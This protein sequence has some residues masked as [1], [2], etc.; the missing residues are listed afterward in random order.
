LG[1]TGVTEDNLASVNDA[2]ND[3]DVTGEQANTAAK[4]QAIVDGFNAILAN[5]DGT[6]N[7]AINPTQ[8]NYTAIGVSGVDTAP[9]VSLLGDV[10]DG[11]NRTNV[12]T[13]SQVQTLANAVQ[14]VMNGNPTE[15]QLAAL[16]ITGVTSANLGTVQAALATPVDATQLNTLAGVQSVVN[17]AIYATGAIQDAAQNNTATATTPSVAQYLAAGVTGVDANNLA[18]I[19]DALN[20]PDVTGAQADTTAKVQAIVDG[21]NAILNNA[22][23]AATPN[24]TLSNYAAIGVNGVDSAVKVNLL[25]DVIDTL[26]PA[27]V[28]QVAQVQAL[29]DAVSAV[30]TAAA[31]STGGTS[32]LSKAQLEALGI[33]GVT[34]D[35]LSAVRAAIVATAD[36]GN[37]VD[38]LSELQSLVSIAATNAANALTALGTFAQANT[39]GLATPTG[40]VPAVSLYAQAGVTGVSDSNLHA[41]NDA[42]ASLAVDSTAVSTTAQVQAIVDAYNAILGEANDSTNTPGDTTPDATPTADPT[43]ANYA[44]IG[45]NIGAAATDTENLNLLNDIIGGLQTTDVDSIAKI[46]TLA[47]IANAIQTVAANGS[48]TLTEADFAQVGLTGVTPDNLPAVLAVIA[49]TANDGS[50]TDSL[51]ELQTLITSAASA[52]SL[53]LS[54]ISAYAELNN[55]GLATASGTAPVL[56]DFTAAGVFGV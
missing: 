9:E 26:A 14:A 40:A 27:D 50:Q 52:A 47:N 35:N 53:A 13:V 56:A 21:F 15:A 43:A 45:A 38:S 42:L 44:A 4:V 30:M 23:I 48:A 17:N 24:P 31:V 11:K 54:T 39:Q 28:S 32:T 7:N 10:I 16:G 46:N 20:D 25:G 12:D 3:A 2:L 29:A 49:A 22:T 6:A 37:A 34:D 51:S 33:T 8:A 41:I 18:A 1:V 55:T 19:N 5:A 36:D